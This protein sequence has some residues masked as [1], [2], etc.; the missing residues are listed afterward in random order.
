MKTL[1][2]NLLCSLFILIPFFAFPQTN[3]GIKIGSMFNGMISDDLNS[4]PRTSFHGGIFV[5]QS[6]G[7]KIAA[8]AELRYSYESWEN[9]PTFGKIQLN[10]HFLRLPIEVAFSPFSWLD[11]HMGPSIGLNLKE[12]N[13]IV[14]L[15]GI[16]PTSYRPARIAKWEAGVEM[17]MAVLLAK[18]N[19][20]GIRYYQAL[21]S[22]AR[23]DSFQGNQYQLGVYLS[24]K[25]INL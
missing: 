22:S 17:G 8:Q 18:R 6:L 9:R 15:E 13:E 24:H 3:L 7:D 19:K 1:Q 21:S 4:S 25:L 12:R 20:L 5:N 2:R 23:Y 10:T 11:I 14:S 16:V